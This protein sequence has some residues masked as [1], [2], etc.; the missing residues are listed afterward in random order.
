MREVAR[1]IVA[2]AFAISAA[3]GVAYVIS[4][5]TSVGDD[6]RSGLL[7]AAL[8]VVLVAIPVRLTL[9]IRSRQPPRDR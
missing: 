9:W 7:R 5:V 6:P 3:L 2:L 4:G 1:L 8:G